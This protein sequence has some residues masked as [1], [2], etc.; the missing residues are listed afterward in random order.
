MPID[1]RFDSA[2]EMPYDPKNPNAGGKLIFDKSMDIREMS[3]EDRAKL[4]D[5]RAV[6]ERI[7][8]E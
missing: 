3:R 7:I 2:E 8:K 1:P 4:I 6:E 5:L